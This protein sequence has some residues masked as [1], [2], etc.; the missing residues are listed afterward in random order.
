MHVSSVSPCFD[1]KE[2]RSFLFFQIPFPCSVLDLQK[3]VS[4]DSLWHHHV[5][6]MCVRVCV[7]VCV[8]V[9]GGG[10]N[11]CTK[12]FVTV[13]CLRKE[14]CYVLSLL[15]GGLECSVLFLLFKPCRFMSRNFL[16][17][18][19]C[20]CSSCNCWGS[21]LYCSLRVR[22]L[23]LCSVYSRLFHALQAHQLEGRPTSV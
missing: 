19:L 17:P 5:I 14:L 22:I 9:C 2:S 12:L 1:L 15:L 4:V 6:G 21:W 23:K 18:I 10:G 3:Y 13:L 11:S 8:C 20:L 7:C 16:R